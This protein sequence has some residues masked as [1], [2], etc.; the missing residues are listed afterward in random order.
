[1]SH[2]EMESEK[3]QV[4]NTSTDSV[5]LYCEED[6]HRGALLLEQERRL[7]VWESVKLHRRPLLICKLVYN[8]LH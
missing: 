1:M 3:I 4:E 7:G 8:D 5:S 6:A 2:K